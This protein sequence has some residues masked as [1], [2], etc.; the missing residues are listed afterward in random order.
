MRSLTIAII[1]CAGIAPAS[2]PAATVPASKAAKTLAAP[3]CPAATS[4]MAG[5]MSRW[6]GKP[7]KPQRLGDLPPADTY[8]AVYRLDERGCMVPVMYRDVRPGR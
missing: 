8:A 6:R 3:D 2:Q 4:E 7:V 5:R 1:L